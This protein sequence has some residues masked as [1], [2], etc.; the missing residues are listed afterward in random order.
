M[1]QTLKV[2]DLVWID[3]TNR[4]VSGVVL[5]V[6]DNGFCKLRLD[7]GREDWFNQRFLEVILESR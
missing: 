6:I 2:G 4:E 3:G 5:A 1:K 7:N